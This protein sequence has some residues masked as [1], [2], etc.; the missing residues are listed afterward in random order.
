VKRM[1]Q[2]RVCRGRSSVLLPSLSV[3]KHQIKTAARL[4][5]LPV[6]HQTLST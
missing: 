5:H 3:D 4:T 2:S 6:R 1:K